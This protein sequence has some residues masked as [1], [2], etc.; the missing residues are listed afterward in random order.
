MSAA[1]PIVRLGTVDS[2]QT[3][4]FTL[5]AE[6]A[7]HGTAVVADTQQQGRGRHGRIW[8]DAPGQCLLL[9]VLL[10]PTTA[11]AALPALS[12]VAAVAVADALEQAAGLSPRLKWPNDV[13]VEGRKI[14]GILL[15]SRFGADPVVVIGIGLNLGRYA[16]PDDMREH[17]TSVALAGGRWLD[18]ET[19]LNAVLRSLHDWV[20]RWTR[21]GAAPVRARWCALADTL[22]RH[23]TVDGVAGVATD[24]D[25]DG[26]LLV[27]VDGTIRRVVSGEVAVEGR[28]AARH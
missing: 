19:A 8:R 23:I 13:L 1:P 4:A 14:A 21:E 24:L 26:A 17:A 20:E 22:G 5:A 9:S 27:A 12:L 6:G 7:P 28:H 18:R 25:A 10:R 16:V 2:T 11:P 3:V 15:E